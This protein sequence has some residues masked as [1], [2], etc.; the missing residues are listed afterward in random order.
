MSSPAPNLLPTQRPLTDGELR[1]ILAPL[2]VVTSHRLLSGG[3][4]SAVQAVALADGT[5]VVV[6]TS[7]PE[8][9][10][11]DGRTPL[12]TYEHD[13]LRAERDMLTL[14]ADVDGVPAPQVLHS[15]FSRTIADVDALVMTR[16]PGTPWDTVASTM[17]P[18]AHAHVWHQVGEIV[19]TMQTVTGTRFGYPAQG[20]AL[21][22]D[23]W[24][25]FVDTLFAVTVADAATWGV[26]IEA[27]RLLAALD[28]IRP[29][30]A[31]VTQPRLVHNDLW[32][33]NVLLDPATGDVRGVVDFERALFGDRL[34]DFCGSETMNVGRNE[35]GFVAGYVAAGG[36]SRWD[37]D[38]RTPSGLDPAAHARLSLYRL[39]AMSVQF[40]EIVPRG[41]SG[42]W[43][44]EHRATIRANR[45]ELFRQ[46]GV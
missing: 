39:W 18:E 41:F 36:P 16:V 26:D 37:A 25:D 19:A 3:T 28:V 1:E 30:L 4:F 31:E 44:A 32:P 15:D 20:F 33:G 40:I 29:H 27:E 5:D 9:A 21:G 11:P 34:Q 8:R 10:L 22:A 17:S 43:V 45:A 24:P 6:K 2:G 7:V 35:R 23:T 38:A 13:M 42:D 46:V 12:L 14:L